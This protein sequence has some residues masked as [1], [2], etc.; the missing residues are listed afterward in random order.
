MLGMNIGGSEGL[1]VRIG[2]LTFRWDWHGVSLVN[3]EGRGLAAGERQVFAR[4]RQL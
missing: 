1:V 2:T 4:M 3:R